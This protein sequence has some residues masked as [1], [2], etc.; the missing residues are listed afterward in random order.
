[1][2]I[3]A[4][5]TIWLLVTGFILGIIITSMIWTCILLIIKLRRDI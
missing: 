3:L 1:M 4:E 2:N 5:L